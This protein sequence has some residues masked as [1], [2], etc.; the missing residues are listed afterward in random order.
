MTRCR[1]RLYKWR[2]FGVLLCMYVT[3]LRAG[4]LSDGRQVAAQ[5]LSNIAR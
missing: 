2:G 3:A 4:N 1:Q 5:K